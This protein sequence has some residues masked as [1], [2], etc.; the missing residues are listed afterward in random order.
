MICKFIFMYMLSSVKLPWTFSPAYILRAIFSL[1]SA[2]INS[3]LHIQRC[4]Q[5]SAFKMEEESLVIP[6]CSD[7]STAVTASWWPA[8][9]RDSRDYPS[10]GRLGRELRDWR[11]WVLCLYWK[12]LI[13]LICAVGVATW[14]HS[15]VV[16]IKFCKPFLQTWK[17]IYA[18]F[19]LVVTES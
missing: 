8:E 9:C 18:W 5:I 19:I 15:L 1:L 4:L 6:L 7:C 17:C 3:A 12:I 2:C 14:Q 13:E 11:D 10:Q 16:T